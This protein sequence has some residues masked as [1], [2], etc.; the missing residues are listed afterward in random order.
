[1][2]SSAAART[3]R[4]RPS[5]VSSSPISA[6]VGAALPDA[7]AAPDP[8]S[9]SAPGALHTDAFARSVGRRALDDVVTSGLPDLTR[10]RAAASTLARPNRCA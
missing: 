9:R 7:A 8:P 3:L 10:V 2:F 4:P 1:M 5:D 6:T